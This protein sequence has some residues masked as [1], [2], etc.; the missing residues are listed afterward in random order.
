VYVDWIVF[1]PG[2]WSS[3]GFEVNAG[4]TDL[5]SLLNYYLYVYQLE[6]T[7]GENL[8]WFTV[9]VP[10]DSV[11]SAGWVNDGDLDTAHNSGNYANLV[12][13]QEAASNG[14]RDVVFASIDNSGATPNVS[15]GFTLT[16]VNGLLP[17]YESETM[18]FI[19]PIAP[20]YAYAGTKDGNEAFDSPD[21]V[22]AP[23]PAPEPSTMLLMGS[24]LSGLF[25]LGSLRKKKANQ[26]KTAA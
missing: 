10:K 5:D 15:W 2:Q 20:V 9:D 7:S 3:T 23:S 25:T 24:G 18:W 13:E 26:K 4:N 14:L 12:T 17:G 16:G 22:P 6:N 8:D 19:S 11:V 1:G 21:L